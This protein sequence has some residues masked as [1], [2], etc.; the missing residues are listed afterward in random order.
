LLHTSEIK[1]LLNFPL[2]MLS[3]MMFYVTMLIILMLFSKQAR[4]QSTCSLRATSCPRAP[5][6]WPLV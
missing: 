5:R 4:G 1:F 6:W 3:L 2:I